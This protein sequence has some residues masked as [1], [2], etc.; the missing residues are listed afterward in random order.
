MDRIKQVLIWILGA[1]A[2]LAVFGA[3]W[4]FLWLGWAI[5]LPI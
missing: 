3:L 2:V 5:G 1:I 4:A